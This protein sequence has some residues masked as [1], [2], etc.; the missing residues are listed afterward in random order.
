MR[1]APSA[2]L[3]ALPL[4]RLEPI[5]MFMLTAS[6]GVGKATG[7]INSARMSVSDVKEIRDTLTLLNEGCCCVT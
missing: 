1:R 2:Q 3:I 4:L 6:A 5:L 7:V